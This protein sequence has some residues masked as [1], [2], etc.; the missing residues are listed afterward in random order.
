MVYFPSLFPKNGNKEQTALRIQ[1][2][3]VLMNQIINQN[4]DYSSELYKVEKSILENDKPNIW[5]VHIE[6]NMEREIEVEFYKYAHS[7]TQDSSISIT[8]STVFGFYT[9][10]LQII[11]KNT[12]T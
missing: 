2:A 6:G 4:E 10:V 11:D 5:N 8:D 7:V 3:D 9:K 1:R 12:P